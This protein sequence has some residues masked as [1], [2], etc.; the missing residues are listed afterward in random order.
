MLD[1]IL[2]VEYEIVNCPNVY[3]RKKP[4]NTINTIVMHHTEVNM[5]LTRDIFFS[6]K[7]GTSAH[8]V[9][10]KNG[11]IWQFVPDKHLARHAGVSSWRGCNDN[12]DRSIGIEIVNNGFISFTEAQ[13]VSVIKLT[14][15]LMKKHPTIEQRN[16]IAHSD[17]APNRKVDPSVKFNW[18]LLHKYNIGLWYDAPTDKDKVLFSCFSNG[19][20]VE[21]VQRK[22]HKLGYKITV[23]G[24]CG[25]QTISIVI[26]FKRHF[27][28]FALDD[29]WYEYCDIVLDNLLKQANKTE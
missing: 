16:I 29:K 25:E 13:M 23:D 26:A 8:Y 2:E 3:T 11:K 28:Q 14:H 6:R 5:A 19:T 27:I 7:I 22:L 17:I 12:N 4:N 20:I 24:V 9:I 21:Q 10:E 1:K 15:L 18:K